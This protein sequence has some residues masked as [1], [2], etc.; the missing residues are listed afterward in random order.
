MKKKTANFLKLGFGGVL[1]GFINGLLGAGGGMLAVPFL[2]SQGFSVKSAHANSVAVIMPLSFFT[3]VLYL[4]ENKVTLYDAVVFMPWG[5]V[6]TLLGVLLLKRLPDNL[7]RKIF[8]IFMLWAGLRL[9]LRY[10]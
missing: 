8:A 7:L 1:V 3:A 5:L 10:S 6:G 2:K 4:I 9:I